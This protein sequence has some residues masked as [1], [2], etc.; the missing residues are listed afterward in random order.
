[1]DAGERPSASPLLPP[2]PPPGGAWDALPFSAIAAVVETAAQLPPHQAART[3]AALRLL[4]RHWRSVVD[5]CAPAWHPPP[6]RTAAQITP[7][8]TRWQHLRRLSLDEC[9]LDGAALAALARCR[10]LAHLHL[11]LVR[12]DQP[13]FEALAQLPALRSLIYTQADDPPFPPSRLRWRRL[14]WPACSS[15]CRGARAAAAG[16]HEALAAV[17]APSPAGAC[18][19]PAFYRACGAHP[20]RRALPPT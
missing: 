14:S 11:C 8:L 7:L 17:A 20:S 6:S 18:G 16:P 1:M 19:P 4:N 5:D 2:D 10:R 15:R 3:L 12:T 13:L 9:W